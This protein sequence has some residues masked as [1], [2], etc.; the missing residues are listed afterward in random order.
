M[1]ENNENPAADNGV[2]TR[3]YDFH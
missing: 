2:D 1:E 3:H